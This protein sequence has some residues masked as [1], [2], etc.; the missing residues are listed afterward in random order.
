MDRRTI[1]KKD[2]RFYIDIPFTILF[3]GIIA[4]GLWIVYGQNVVWVTRTVV[5]IVL[6]LITQ[7]DFV[8]KKIP[9]PYTNMLLFASL[10]DMLI[11][12]EGMKEKIVWF[13][14]CIIPLYFLV[15]YNHK[16]FG[17]GDMRVISYSALLL[18]RRVLLMIFLAMFLA[19]VY[20]FIR[21]FFKH[22]KL[23]NIPMG[24]FFTAAIYVLLFV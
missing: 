12:N 1:Y 24:G 23:K 20:I 10:V 16:Y 11:S 4:V 15:Y 22:E 13:F 17:G 6:I 7:S 18:G 14:I 5:S 9:R 21:R 19:I 2:E 3:S 8:Y